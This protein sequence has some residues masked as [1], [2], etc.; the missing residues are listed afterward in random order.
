MA[1]DKRPSLA[2]DERPE[3]GSRESRRLR[4]EGLI[5]GVVYGGGDCTAVRI[6]AR[7]LRS[8]LLASSAVIDV[9]VAGGKS[10]PVIVKDQQHHPVRDEIVHIDLLEVRLDEKIHTTVPLEL[11]GAEE[12]PG[13]KEGGVV[14]H[15]TRELNIEALPTSIPERIIADVSGMEAAA[16]MH[17][18]ELTAPEGVVFLD[19]PDETIVATVTIPTEVEEP[20]VEEETE[21]VGEEGEAAAAEGE[22]EEGAAPSEGEGGGGEE[23]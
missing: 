22:G 21:L 20:E 10:V 14:E 11:E 15:V 16:T 9:S 5:P 13:A 1:Q 4:R 3:T 8:A 23:S 6:N 7:E 19:D 18:S 12:A 17:L 2:V